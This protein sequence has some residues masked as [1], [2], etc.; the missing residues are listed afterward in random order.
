MTS[1][2]G[3][4]LFQVQLSFN[5][6]DPLKNNLLALSAAT[7][8]HSDADLTQIEYEVDIGQLRKSSFV[9]ESGIARDTF[10]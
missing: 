3:T 7:P 2:R 1:V 8:R 9:H 10:G 6:V 5:N 4:F